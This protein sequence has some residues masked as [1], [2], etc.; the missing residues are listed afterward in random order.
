MMSLVQFITHSNLLFNPY[1]FNREV[2][3]RFEKFG[4]FISLAGQTMVYH[5]T[6]QACWD[7]YGRSN[8]RALQ[9]LDLWLFTAG[10][11]SRNPFIVLS[12]KLRTYFCF[13]CAV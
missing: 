12:S 8:P 5:T 11:Q 6:Q 4:N 9:T 2:F 1:F 13:S 3:M 7:L 10:R